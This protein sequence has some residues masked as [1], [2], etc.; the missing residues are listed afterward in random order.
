MRITFKLHVLIPFLLCHASAF[1]WQT[2]KQAIDEWLKFELSGG[3]L[4]SWDFNRYIN[5]PANHDEPGWDM[6]HVVRTAKVQSMQCEGQTCTAKLE[7][8]Y[9]PTKHLK[10]DAVYQHSSGDTE[11]LSVKVTQT[12]RG[13]LLEPISHAPCVRVSELK[14]RGIV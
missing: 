6:V 9:E 7:F 5:A 10:S 1:A 8:V 14:R 2:P 12:K 3:R 11:T 4:Q 13:W